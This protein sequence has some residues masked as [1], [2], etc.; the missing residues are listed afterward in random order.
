MT[1]SL[2]DCK[3]CIYIPAT[4]TV[5]DLIAPDGKTWFKHEEP[6]AY[7]KERG[8][9]IWDFDEAA[10]HSQNRFK[11]E[12]ERIS[13]EDWNEALCCLPP[14]HWTNRSGAETFKMSEMTFG[15]ITAI[16]CKIGANHYR[17]SDSVTLSHDEIVLRC[18]GLE[19]Q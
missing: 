19:Q 1:I 3:D 10:Q 17:L 6:E 8:A 7:A 15:T 2:R 5:I 16:Y 9:E 14:L 12:P 4:G 11:S 18:K 13:A